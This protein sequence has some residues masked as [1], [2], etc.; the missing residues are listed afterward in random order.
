VKR[1]HDSECAVTLDIAATADENLLKYKPPQCTCRERQ[2]VRR[3][4]MRA[5][6]AGGQA[7]ESYGVSIGE[8]CYMTPPR[9]AW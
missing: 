2:R 9:R 1:E 3:E 4:A 6:I 8:G 7:A 5:K